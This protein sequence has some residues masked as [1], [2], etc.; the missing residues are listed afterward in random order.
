MNS[1]LHGIVVWQHGRLMHIKYFCDPIQDGCLVV[2]WNVH[3]WLVYVLVPFSQE[4]FNGIVYASALFLRCMPSTIKSVSFDMW[5]DRLEEGGQLTYIWKMLD[6]GKQPQI[7][8]RFTQKL[9]IFAF[10][11]LFSEPV[12]FC[13]SVSSVRPSVCP[14]VRPSVRL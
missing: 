14:S 4:L 5:D 12:S 6:A 8:V 11:G 3:F 7:K 10:G 9:P 1:Y 2:K 13:Y